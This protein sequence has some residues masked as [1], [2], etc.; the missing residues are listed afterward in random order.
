MVA[1]GDHLPW[2][3]RV[4]GNLPSSCLFWRP[5]HQHAPSEHF[6][7]AVDTKHRASRLLIPQ[8]GPQS[9]CVSLNISKSP[10]WLSCPALREWPTCYGPL[11]LVLFRATSAAYGGS[12]VRSQIRAGAAGLHHS[13]SNARSKLRRQPTPQLTAIPDP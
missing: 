3:R 2:G 13:R 4:E 7:Q 1:P 6:L 12:Q 11:F 9:Y 5:V 10:F 8:Q